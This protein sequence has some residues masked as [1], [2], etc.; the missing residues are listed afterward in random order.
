MDDQYN[1]REFTL[2]DKIISFL[3]RYAL[4]II[5]LVT[6]LTYVLTGQFNQTT[7]KQAMKDNEYTQL[8]SL[9]QALDNKDVERVLSYLS[10]ECLFQAGNNPPVRGQENIRATLEAFFPS[11]KSIKHDL[12]DSFSSGK[13]VVYRGSVVY[14]RLDGS[15]L[16]VPVCDVFKMEGGKIK[17]YYIYIDWNALFN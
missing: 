5:L 9:S 15:M 7:K 6:F 11:V 1:D 17:E 10:P 13:S 8:D 12:Y 2:I 14:E 3:G 16:K 4:L